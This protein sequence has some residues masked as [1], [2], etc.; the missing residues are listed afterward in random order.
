MKLKEI[1]CN[2][3][4]DKAKYHLEEVQSI[5]LPDK[6]AFVHSGFYYTWII[7]NRLF[8]EG[9]LEDYEEKLEEIKDKLV[10]PSQLFLEDED[11]VLISEIFNKIGYNFSLFY[12]DF[13][14]GDFLKDYEFVL[15][16]L[17]EI[18][19]YSVTDSWQNFKILE[20]V[21]D[22]RFKEWKFENGIK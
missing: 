8:D 15:C 22:K 5:G 2:Y 18:G 6:Q 17:E 10:T 11:G 14:K 1:N 4:F 7:K 21:I 13:K 19:I 20:T 9:Y 3:V 12:F 16:D